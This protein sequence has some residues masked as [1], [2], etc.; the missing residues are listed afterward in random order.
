M[1]GL[2]ISFIIKR[3]RKIDK[4]MDYFL[5]LALGMVLFTFGFY[6]QFVG[7]QN[8]YNSSYMKKMSLLTSYEEINAKV[9]ASKGENATAVEI[10]YNKTY[11]ELEKMSQTISNY[12]TYIEDIYASMIDGVQINSVDI[13]PNES[14][15]VLSLIFDKN[16]VM[17][18]YRDRV[19]DLAWV[20][21]HGIVAPDDST[22]TSWEV[23]IDGNA[24]LEK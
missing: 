18:V 22:S 8:D 12:S 13:R 16:D 23:F 20:P 9:E 15:I 14:K 17:Y 7:K 1:K 6:M 24:E 11:S 19:Y 4:I 3:R 5:A 2:Y 10:S 21:V